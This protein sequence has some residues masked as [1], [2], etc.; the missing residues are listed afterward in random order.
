[1]KTFFVLLFGLFILAGCSYKINPQNINSAILPSPSTEAKT[2]LISKQYSTYN[3]KEAK[4]TMYFFKEKEGLLHASDVISYIPYDYTG[5]LY[6][7][8]SNVTFTLRRLTD[9][10]A[11][12]IEEALDAEVIKHNYTL[13]FNDKDEFIIGNDF[14]SQIQVAIRAFEEKIQRQE[15]REDRLL[16]EII[17]PAQ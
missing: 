5:Q 9:G 1:M 13:L 15:D 6:D 2:F 4:I 10:K 11:K 14:A 12:T 8:F 17:I 16:R 3:K 7:L